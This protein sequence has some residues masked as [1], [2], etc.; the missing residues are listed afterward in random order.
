MIVRSGTRCV[1]VIPA[2][3]GSRGIPRKNLKTVA[4]KPLLAWT[5]DAVAVAETPLR[6][7]VS[8]DDDEIASLAAAM[9]AEVVHRPPEL[10]TDESPTE[11]AII[12]AVGAIPD[13]DEIDVVLLL[14]ATSPIRDRDT[15]DRALARFDSSGADSMVGVIESSPFFWRG[16]ID[17]PQPI[18]DVESRPR[19]QDF[20]EADRLYRETGSLYVTAL[21][22]LRE[23]RNRLSGHAVLFPMGRDEGVDIDT[24]ADLVEAERLLTMSARQDV[25]QP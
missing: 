21:R 24:E 23:S 12:H 15:I 6:C 22:A 3:G 17:S 13:A 4:G 18:Y 14:Q 5:I 1:A 16:P 10:A 19:R 2:R 9:G 11:P 20:V 8:T 7:V 25:V